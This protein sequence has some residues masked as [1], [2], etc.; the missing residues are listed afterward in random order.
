MLRR[1][2]A[3]LASVALLNVLIAPAASACERTAGTSVTAGMAGMDHAA[4]NDD[5]LSGTEEMSARAS[6][7]G[8]V[9]AAAADCENMVGACADD[10]AAMPGCASAAFVTSHATGTAV[11]GLE[12]VAPALTL[13]QVGSTIAPDHPPPRA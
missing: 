6:G 3:V 9:V 1:A 5:D 11:L 4:M 12:R 7:Q 8:A 10:C 2:A 13:Y